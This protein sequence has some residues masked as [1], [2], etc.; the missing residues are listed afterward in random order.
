[1]EES[2]KP[3]LE[4]SGPQWVARFPTSR[5][6]ASLVEPFQTYVERFITALERVDCTVRISA[7]RRPSERAWL[8]RQAWDVS[9]GLVAPELVPAK[10]RIGIV[11]DHGDRAASVAAAK[12]MVEGYGLVHR[13]SLSSRHIEGRAIDMTID[14]PWPLEVVDGSGRRVWVRNSADLYEVGASYGVHKLV[15]DP[16]HWSDDGR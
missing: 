11:W 13:P 7:T 16:P 5:T 15:S 4:L 9:R 14:F 10:E 8:M 6:T 3:E 12:A 1:M 2:T